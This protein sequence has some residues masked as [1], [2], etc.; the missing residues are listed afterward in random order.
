METNVN[1]DSLRVNSV[2][3]CIDISLAGGVEL[4]VRKVNSQTNELRSYGYRKE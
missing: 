3:G 4:S 2:V 1:R